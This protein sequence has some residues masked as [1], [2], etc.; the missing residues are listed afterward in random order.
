VVGKLRRNIDRALKAKDVLE[1][2]ANRSGVPDLA[3]RYDIHPSEIQTWKEQLE[4]RATRE[5]GPRLGRWT[6]DIQ[7]SDL[8]A[9]WNTWRSK[10]PSVEPEL[11]GSMLQGADVTGADFFQANLCKATLANA[12]LLR[13]KMMLA[14]LTGADLSGANLGRTNL[15]QANLTQAKLRGARFF[16]ANLEGAMLD[17]TDVTGAH[18]M[19]TNLD[20]AT[21][22][23]LNLTG[24]SFFKAS[25]TYAD[26]RDANL[27]EAGLSE[28]NLSGA[29]LKGADLTGANLSGADLTCAQLSGANLTD[30][31][32][33]ATN[34]TEADFSDAILRGARIERA[35]LVSTILTGADLTGCRIYGISAWALNLSGATQQDLIITREGEP[36]VTVDNVEVAQFMHLLIDNRKIRSVIDTITSKVVL[37]LGRFT[38]ERI[39]VLHAVRDELRQRDYVP[40]VVEFDKPRSQTTDEA[41]TL[42]ARM[43]RFVIAD[44]S[45]AKSVLQELRAIVPDLPSVPVQPLILASQKSR[46][47][48]IFFADMVRF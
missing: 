46:E 19:A 42:L 36:K 17:G 48:S 26:L 1:V 25:L 27:Q 13:A 20:F 39:K 8:A 28:T 34:L 11:S 29:K 30:A 4:K 32:L 44:L 33:T 38:A 10:N 12:G 41:I 37:I 22:R 40:V 18:F 16:G 24:V 6:G 45:D 9:A 5:L 23:N 21:L 14:D 47:C 7:D 3:Q 15:C 2:L 35:S 43:A 31:D